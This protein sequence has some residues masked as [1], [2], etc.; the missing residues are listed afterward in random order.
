[1]VQKD[2]SGN[3]FGWLTYLTPCCFVS[4]FYSVL[5]SRKT[6]VSIHIMTLYISVGECGW[7]VEGKQVGSMDEKPQVRGCYNITFICIPTNQE[8]V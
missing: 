8:T 1:M 3:K 6:S 7:G 2:R 5:F 4:V